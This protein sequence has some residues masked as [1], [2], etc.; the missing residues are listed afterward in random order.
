ME[1]PGFGLKIKL[2]RSEYFW[3]DDVSLAD[4]LFYS[5]FWHNIS[6]VVSSNINYFYQFFIFLLL[7]RLYFFFFFRFFPTSITWQIHTSTRVFFTLRQKHACD[8]QRHRTD[9]RRSV[10]CCLDHLW[11]DKTRVW[12]IMSKQSGGVVS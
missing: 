9:D 10:F 2:R 5:Y 6:Y 8:F 1:N 7:F 12:R 11:D 4:A 3:H